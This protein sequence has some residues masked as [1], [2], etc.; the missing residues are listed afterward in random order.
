[1][2]TSRKRPA[3]PQLRLEE[4]V[5][6]HAVAIEEF[7]GSPGIRDRG[8]LESAIG[9][10]LATFRGKNLYRTPFKRAAAI[11]ESIVPNH[12]FVDGNKRTAI[13]AM[14]AW[15]EREGHAIEAKPG[16]LRDLALSIAAHGFTIDQIA[17][18]LEERSQPI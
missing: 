9:R 7:G 15:L 10:P 3:E 2:P 4:L 8:V 18:W 12:G 14:A 1:L 13:Y 17:A 5:W 16:E 6:L 11:A